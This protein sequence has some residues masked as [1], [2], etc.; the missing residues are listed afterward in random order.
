MYR[1]PY[2]TMNKR[3]KDI[4]IGSKERKEIY[5]KYVLISLFYE[6]SKIQGFFQR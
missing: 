4:L 3:F 6:E 2:F 1:F 5:E